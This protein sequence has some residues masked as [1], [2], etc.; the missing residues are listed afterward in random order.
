MSLYRKWKHQVI[1]A[2]LGC[3][4]LYNGV[5]LVLHITLLAVIE[6]FFTAIASE[7]SKKV[8][9]K[10]WFYGF[11]YLHLQHRLFYLCKDIYLFIDPCFQ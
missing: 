1:D 5:C 9:H 10:V 3:E 8:T 4:T 7:I 6:T 2:N 11:N